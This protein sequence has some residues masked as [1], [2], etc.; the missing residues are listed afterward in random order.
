M[1]VI[2]KSPAQIAQ[3]HTAGQ[4]VRRTFELLREHVKPGVT[5]A[6]L[7]E[8]A[9]QFIRANGAEPV[10]KGYVPGGRRN[11]RDAIPFPGT[12]C[13]SVNDVI[14][15]GI[16]SKK[17]KLRDGDII[18]VDI[19]LKLN[20]WIGDACETYAVGNV[21]P[22][23]QRLL[24]VTRQCLQLGIEQA[25]IGNTLRDIGRVIQQHAE[26]AGFAVVRE[27][28]GHGLGRQLHEE[29]SVLHYDEPRNTRKIVEG[30]V[31]TIEPMINLG[32]ARTKQD[33]DGWT[34]RTADGKLSAQF[35]HTLAITADG[36]L[37][38][39]Q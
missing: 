22:E 26:A 17:I 13:A 3:L 10:Y 1:A 31:F 34:V 12:I 8:L 33:N 21:A 39:T 4:L 5:T 32:G 18:G 37:V 20:G 24:D 27:Y 6:E 9:E 36:P 29:P 23:T 25:R 19:G 15:H 16:P 30:M 7:D 35:E 28:T 2:L 11:W 38:L 14:C